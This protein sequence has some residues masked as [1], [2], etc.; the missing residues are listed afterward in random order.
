[1]LLVTS[2]SVFEPHLLSLLLLCLLLLL[3]NVLHA[4]LDTFVKINKRRI[5][6]SLLCL[7]DA[8]VFGH[9][10]VLYLSP[11]QVRFLAHEPEHVLQDRAN[12]PGKIS[13]KMPD[14]AQGH[15][16]TCLMPDFARKVPEVNRLAIGDEE[17]LT[18]HALCV[19][20]DGGQNFVDMEESQNSED[21]T[22]GDILNIRKIEQVCVVADLKLGLSLAARG[23][24]LGKQ[25]NVALAEDACRTDSAGQEVF[26]VAVRLEYGGLCV[27]LHAW[28]SNGK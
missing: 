17:G 18:I 4:S 26:G 25:L 1:M 12:G 14:A 3:Q 28:I 24:H 21:V 9:A 13:A 22:M 27:G 20:R 2:F 19:Q 8:V 10:T 6:Q 23:D 11:G 5:S 15:A 16:V 7:V